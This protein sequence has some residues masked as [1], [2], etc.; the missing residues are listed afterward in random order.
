MYGE[1][2]YLPPQRWLHSL[3]HGAVVLLYD[4]C[5]SKTEVDKL[6]G[7]LKSC[8]YRHIITPYRL[9][10]ERPLAL[11]AWAASLEM[12][13]FDQATAKEFMKN[14]AKTGPEKV[15]RQG[16]YKVMLIEAAKLVTDEN[17]SEICPDKSTIM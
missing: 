5:A 12:S 13:F 4:P 17:D 9:S 8:L 14:Y 1:Y 10:K 7:L 2:T 11:V 3:E 16:Q 6:R 15:A